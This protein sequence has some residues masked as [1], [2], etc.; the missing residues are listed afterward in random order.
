EATGDRDADAL[1]AGL[2]RPRDRL[3]QH[4]AERHAPLELLRDVLGDQVRVELRVADLEDVHLHDL[5]GRLAEGL[6]E[7]LDLRAALADDDARL[8]GL[9]G[10]RDLVRR[11]LDVDARDRGVTQAAA[12]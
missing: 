3:L 1:G 12:D 6:T 5:A 10:D 8:R 4:L 9:D 7:L 11:A 2:H